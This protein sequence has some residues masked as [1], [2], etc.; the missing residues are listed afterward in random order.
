MLPWMP[1]VAARLARSQCTT[2]GSRR[3][4]RAWSSAI[5]VWSASVSGTF[6]RASRS[7]CRTIGLAGPT[8][9]V[10]AVSPSSTSRLRMPPNSEFPS[11]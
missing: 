5:F 1:I 4:S 9:S 7:S 11:S 6:A 2:T 3:S 10:L 8:S